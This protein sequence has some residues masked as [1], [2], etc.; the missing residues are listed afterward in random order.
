MTKKYTPFSRIFHVIQSKNVDWLVYVKDTKN[1]LHKQWV[2][3]PRSDAEMIQKELEK[4]YLNEV[5]GVT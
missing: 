5:R 4:L 2:K 3:G 1:K